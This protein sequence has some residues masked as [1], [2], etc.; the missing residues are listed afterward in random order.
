MQ[1]L[2]EEVVPLRFL[3]DIRGEVRHLL[4]QVLGVDQHLALLVALH[5]A[6]ELLKLRLQ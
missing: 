3:V 6:G 5:A 1:V 2:L 4:L